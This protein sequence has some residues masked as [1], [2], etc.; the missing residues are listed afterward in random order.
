MSVELP[1]AEQMRAV[2]MSVSTAAWDGYDWPDV[3]ASM[4]RLN[5]GDVEVAF[6]KGYVN[7]FTDDDLN[8]ELAHELRTLMARHGQR[9]TVLSAHIDLGEAGAAESMAVRIR[10]AA[11]LGARYLISNAASQAGRDHFEQ[12]LD[13]MMSSAREAGVKLL[14]E[15][16]GD[17]SNNLIN[18]ASELSTLLARLDASAA[19]INYDPGNL[20][21]HCP[22]LSPLDDALQAI[23]Q[24]DHLH[25][26]AVSRGHD[27]YHFG[28]L[29]T[30]DIDY[31][32]IV[33]ALAA[34]RL[35]FSLELPFR[36]R[37]DEHAQ[38]NKQAEPLPLEEIERDVAASLRWTAQN[39]PAL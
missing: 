29:G 3:F 25:L 35:P 17:G 37:R 1:S 22:A 30:G 10:F 39:H 28:A 18:Q 9:C 20:I 23:P 12:G 6:I 15:N 14:F 38:P 21:S 4:A 31:A 2:G 32:P 33:E 5:I 11:A 7:E 24:S 13:H 8:D 27:G 16:P 36:L 34:R 19:G 26:K